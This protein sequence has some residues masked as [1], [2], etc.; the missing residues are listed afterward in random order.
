MVL[1]AHSEYFHT[2]I[3]EAVKQNTQDVPVVFVD[4]DYT[5][6]SNLL[7]YMY[8]GKISVNSSEINELCDQAERF[9]I[10]RLFEICKQLRDIM[11][12]KPDTSNN[13]SDSSLKREEG[14]PMRWEYI[15]PQMSQHTSNPHHSELG[16]PTSDI[17]ESG[18]T[19]PENRT[20]DLGANISESGDTKQG[21]STVDLDAARISDISQN[22]DT[23]WEDSKVDL[24]ARISDI[25]Q[26]RDTSWEDSKVDLAARISDIS[27]NRDTSWEDSKVDLAARIS[28]I[29]QSRD[30]MP[31]NTKVDLG[32]CISSISESRDPLQEET[33]VDL[34][35]VKREMTDSPD[36]YAAEECYRSSKRSSLYTV[37]IVNF[38]SPPTTFSQSANTMLEDSKVGL[39]AAISD[40]SQSGPTMPED[41][42]S[43]LA[44][45][46]SDIS[47]HGD[48]TSEDNGVDLSIVKQEMTDSPDDDA[49]ECDKRSK[50]TFL[51]TIKTINFLSPSPNASQSTELESAHS[52]GNRL[53]HV[54]KREANSG[55]EEDMDFIDFNLRPDSVME[56]SGK[57]KNVFDSPSV[58]K[59][60]RSRTAS[61][62]VT[63][64]TEDMSDTSIK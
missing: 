29:A 57:R 20:V 10:R 18:D 39:G 37:K 51:N 24:A 8:T 36:D 63:I 21:D 62:P 17:L 55:D 59:R 42:M 38:S 7:Q 12:V 28:D 34:G 13:T 45:P 4:S 52:D 11:K 50:R 47:E 44:A 31:E 61:G 6:I 54:V 56:H 60:T 41:S 26:N 3:D 58:H 32:A 5:V 23:S 43:D 64:K 9:S 40:A 30:T 46:R 27:Q 1:A 16:R 33:K 25:S 15:S 22:R 35:I 48:T 19:I 49:D 53:E 14:A 2:V